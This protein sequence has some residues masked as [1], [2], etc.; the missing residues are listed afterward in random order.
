MAAATRRRPAALIGRAGLLAGILAIVAGILGMH[1]LTGNHAAHP[2]GAAPPP[3]SVAAP[4]AGHSGPDMSGH[5]HG[6]QSHRGQSPAAPA[7]GH[8]G[9]DTSAV[10]AVACTGS[11][12]GVAQPG[13][14]CTPLAKAG[15][16]AAP[17]PSSTGQWADAHF[18]S[19]ASAPRS[20]D[21]RPDGPC[22]GDLSISRT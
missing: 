19:G 5:S 7:A 10:S 3:S 17:E 6:G 14:G 20:Y 4:A 9:P 8:S 1:T 2:L 15:S 21:Y 13:A 18:S 22:P 11:L 12:D 16:L